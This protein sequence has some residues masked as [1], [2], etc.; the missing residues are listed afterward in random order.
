[1][2]EHIGVPRFLFVDFPLGNSA[3]KPDDV[4]SQRRILDQAFRLFETATGPRSTFTS[5][6][7]WSDD[8]AWKR[9]YRAFAQLSP[10]ELQQHRAAFDQQAAIARQIFKR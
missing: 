6:E 4:A 3:G 9:D 8:S 7:H 2:I 1:M 5:P 10:D